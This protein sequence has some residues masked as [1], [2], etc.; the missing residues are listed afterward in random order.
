M[1]ELGG[2]VLLGFNSNIGDRHRGVVS[3]FELTESS[4]ILSFNESPFI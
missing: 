1:S 4:F 3:V 2:M